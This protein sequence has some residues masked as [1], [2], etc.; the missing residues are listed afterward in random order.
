MICTT[1][2]GFTGSKMVLKWLTLLE[3]AGIEW[4]NR[5]PRGIIEK[6]VRERI[7]GGS[8]VNTHEIN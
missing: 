4:E 2:I 8:S 3:G 5:K 1:M 7:M 6:L